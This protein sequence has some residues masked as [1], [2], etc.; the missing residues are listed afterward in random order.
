MVFIVPTGQSDYS[1]TSAR[2]KHATP[3]TA[4]RNHSIAIV[5]RYGLCV[6]QLIRRCRL[7]ASHWLDFATTTIAPV[8]TTQQPQKQGNRPTSR[9]PWLRFGY[10]M[11]DRQHTPDAESKYCQIKGCIQTQPM[12]I[13]CIRLK[14]E[15][16]TEGE[17][18]VKARMAKGEIKEVARRL[19]RRPGLGGNAPP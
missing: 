6:R 14:R 4:T 10:A 11:R 17:P 13:S 1:G 16:P 2:P 15:P 19:V 9:W 12:I 18:D 3:C 8:Y 5:C 7:K